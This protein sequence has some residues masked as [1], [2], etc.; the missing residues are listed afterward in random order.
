MKSQSL[1]RRTMV[2]VLSAELLCAIAFSGTA[3]WHERRSRMHAFDEMLQGRSDSLLGAVQDAEDPEDNVTID[4]VE[5]R[6]PSNDVYAVYNRGGRLLGSSKDAPEML[7]ARQHAGFSERVSNG[8]VYRVLE[9]D[10]LRVIYRADN[11]GVGLRRPI[12]IVYAAPTAHIR[13]E[14]LEAAGFYVLVSLALLACTAAF[15]VFLLRKV[16]HPIEELAAQAAG[17][18]KDSLH[19]EPPSSALRVKELAPLAQTLSST[20]ASLK[21]AFENEQRFVSDA[22]HELKTAVAVVR[23]T[24]QVL[25]MRDRSREEYARGLDRLLQDNQRVEDLVSRMLTLARLEQHAEPEDATTDFAQAVRLAV[26]N[27]ASFAEARLIAV[28]LE[29]EAGVD[30]R[31]SL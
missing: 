17:V 31:L 4:P 30:I 27:L 24:I 13:H 22:A 2:I 8:H 18:S 10:A 19:F 14:I 25:S 20:I 23:S 12:T 15:L 28:T 26:D 21:K 29:A 11:G 6:L 9:R 16:L 5:L 7:M 1:I 3:L